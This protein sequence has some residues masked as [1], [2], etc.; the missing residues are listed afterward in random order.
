MKFLDLFAGIG[1]F[2][3]GLE[4]SGHTCIGHVEIDKYA[5]K[6]YM[7]M[8]GLE[9]CPY[10]VDSGPNSCKMCSPEVRE[11]CDGK[12]CNGEW[13][14]K[15]IK[16]IRAGE[17]PK[18]EIWTLGFPCTDISISGRMAGLH[19]ERSGLFFTVVGLLK[20]TAPQD[21]PRYLIVENVKHLVSSEKGT[22]FTTVLFEL[23]EAGYD[24]EWCVV[25][26]KEFGVPQHR[27]RVYLVGH[28]RN[29]RAGEIFPLGRANPAPVKRLI[30]GKQGKRVY[31]PSGTSITLTANGVGFAGR[32]GLYAVEQQI[33]PCATF[34]DLSKKPQFTESA[35]CLRARQ[36]SGIGNFKGE[37]SGVFI[38]EGHPDCVRAVI[39]P[40]RLNKRQNGR[41]FKESGEPCFTLTCQNQHGVL[42]CCYDEGLPIREAKAEGYTT[43]HHGD[44]INLAYPN[45]RVSRGRVGKQCSQTLLTG[46][47]MGVM[48]CCRIRRLTPR[49]CWRLQAFEDFLFDRARAAGISDAQLYKQAGNAV[50]VNV[51]YEIGLQLA[52]IGGGA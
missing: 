3:R 18:A 6:S 21:K 23:W 35:R 44:G 45:S 42:I 20:G 19:G 27:E 52:E 34:I 43:A 5:N 1:G 41:R 7:A 12:T 39:T 22:A 48:L 14:A 28:L 30:D 38:C 11:D 36:Y 4:R 10:G 13:Y 31:D 2:R 16:Q 51:V 24:T 26:S 49:E 50:T 29:G 9:A 8:Y 25:N 17:I 33:P 40:G 37:T 46:G 32:T 47:S 15:D